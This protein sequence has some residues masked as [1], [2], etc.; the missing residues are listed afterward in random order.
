MWCIFALL[1]AR[2]AA[3][4]SIFA[5][6][7]LENVNSNPAKVVRTIVILFIAWGIV[8]ISGAYKQIL[9]ISERNWWFIIFSGL[10]A[11]IFWL[12]KTDDGKIDID[13]ANKEWF[14]NINPAKSHKTDPLFENQPEAIPSGG[15]TAKQNFSTFQQAKTCF[16]MRVP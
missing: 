3:L 5:K 1:S 14:M 11:G 13:A 2:T 7:G 9:L 6:V 16:F 4:A 12:H 8:S 10:S 15:G